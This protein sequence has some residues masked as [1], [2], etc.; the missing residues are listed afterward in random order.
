MNGVMNWTEMFP[1]TSARE[2]GRVMNINVKWGNL[3]SEAQRLIDGF[4]ERSCF[5][6]AYYNI[7]L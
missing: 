4:M 6:P 1:E 5:K 3:F 7:N 2:L